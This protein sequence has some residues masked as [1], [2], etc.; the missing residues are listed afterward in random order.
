MKKGDVVVANLLEYDLFELFDLEKK[1]DLDLNELDHK[2][3]QLQK[4]YHPDKYQR[5][6]LSAHITKSYIILKS[7]LKRAQYLL[8]LENIMVNSQ[9]KDSIK[10]PDEILEIILE[11]R[12]KLSL[13]DS[14]NEYEVFK[15]NKIELKDQLIIKINDNF[16][17]KN[18]QEAANNTIYLRYVMKLLEEIDKL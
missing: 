18:Y 4:K 3:F 14:A 9:D 15:K 11:D 5:D 13:L 1:F 12:E 16:L 2:Y 17:D 10:P 8:S 6:D 7:H